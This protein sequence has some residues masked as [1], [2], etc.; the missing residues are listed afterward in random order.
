MQKTKNDRFRQLKVFVEMVIE[1][2][3]QLCGHTVIAISL[4]VVLL[5]HNLYHR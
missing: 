4:L 2:L 1:Q 3:T 5:Q